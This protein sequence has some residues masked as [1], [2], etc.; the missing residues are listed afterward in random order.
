MVWLHGACQRN[1]RLSPWLL[2]RWS[3]DSSIDSHDDDDQGKSALV[4]LVLR[5]GQ[6]RQEE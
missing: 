6:S 1:A 3:Y 4:L 2:R 5:N